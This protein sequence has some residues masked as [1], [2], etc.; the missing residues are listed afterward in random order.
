MYRLN[1]ITVY[2]S[3]A[4]ASPHLGKVLMAQNNPRS[5]CM[6]A[7]TT[8]IEQEVTPPSRIGF[9]YEW[10][11]KRSKCMTAQTTPIEQEVTPPSRI[12]FCYEWNTKISMRA[13]SDEESVILIVSPKFATVHDHVSFQWTLKIHGTTGRLNESDDEMEEEFDSPSDY[14]AVELYFVDG[15]ISQVSPTP[16]KS[17]LTTNYNARVNSKIWRRRSR[18]KSVRDENG[19]MSRKDTVDFEKKFA[20]VMEQERGRLSEANRLRVGDPPSRRGS[21]QTIHS[22]QQ[23]P[24]HEHLFKKLLISC[25][26]SCERRRNSFLYESRTEDESDDM[27]DAESSDDEEEKCFECRDSN[28]EHVHDVGSSDCGFSLVKE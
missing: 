21:I 12:G 5:K 27:E 9:C 2:G 23:E 8:P 14:V 17:F 10:N 20:E 25:C 4:S 3:F 16:H 13:V 19:K 28:K 24:D 22:H 15:P 1:I 18:K 11:T 6:T 26:E 7:Q